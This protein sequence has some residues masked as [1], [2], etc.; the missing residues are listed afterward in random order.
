MN[1]D[2]LAR[3][4]YIDFLKKSENIK[5]IKEKLKHLDRIP[6]DLILQKKT[7]DDVSADIKMKDGD[8][9]YYFELKVQNDIKDKKNQTIREYFGHVSLSQIIGAINHKNRYT[10]VF[11][12]RIS[13]GNYTH[14]EIAPFEFFKYIV[15]KP[16]IAFDFYIGLNKPAVPNRCTIYP[17]KP[18]EQIDDFEYYITDKLLPLLHL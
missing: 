1:S 2:K 10:F 3:L 4:W 13:N 9:V 16:D 17:S 12:R 18:N 6:L 7:I 11:M 5:S 8:D 14:E 15:P